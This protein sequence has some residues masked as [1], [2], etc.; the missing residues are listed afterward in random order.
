[1]GERR[2]IYVISDATGNTAEQMV[3]AA[4]VQ[5]D[6]APPALRIL[7]RVR[8]LGD[9][10]E[11]IN[12]AARSDALVV[13]TLVNPML[14]DHLHRRARELSLDCVDLIGPLLLSLGDWLEVRPVGRP[15][16]GRALDDSY[17]RRM[18]ALEFTVNADDGRGIGR[19]SRADIVLV[20]VSRTSKTPVATYLAGQGYKV[21]NVPIVHG[22][23]VPDELLT[24]GPGRVYALTI[25]A[26]KLVDIRANRLSQLG[27]GTSGDYADRDRVLDELRS[28][29]ALYRRHGWPVINV[30]HQAVEETAS[31]IL[32]HR[33]QRI[34]DDGSSSGPA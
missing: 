2:R 1:M 30:T 8:T 29:H 10:D 21:A 6:V 19:L 17:Y 13:H 11:A 22:M 4:L 18:E 31:W 24:L 27:V 12:A 25:D 20:G 7:P 32:R 3:R 26:A 5:F 23:P 28:A 33:A 15:G 14:V 9:I 16:H 34:A